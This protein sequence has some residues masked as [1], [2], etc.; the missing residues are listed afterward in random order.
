M[1]VPQQM[2]P[3]YVGEQQQ[4]TGGPIGYNYPSQLIYGPTGVPMPHQYYPQVN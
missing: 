1:N 2:N 3:T 4:Y